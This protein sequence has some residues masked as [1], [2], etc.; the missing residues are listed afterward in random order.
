MMAYPDIGSLGKKAL[1]HCKDCD[2]SGPTVLIDDNSL[3]SK[4]AV[5][6]AW[7]K[8]S[9]GAAGWSIEEIEHLRDEV[10]SL[11]QQLAEA[12]ENFK[13]AMEALT[14][15]EPVQEPMRIAVG[16]RVDFMMESQGVV[17]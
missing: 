3:K 17:L 14:A 8:G 5:A 11:R 12:A 4:N 15:P 1:I 16:Q 2:G 13:I 9:L 7:N 10:V 6:E